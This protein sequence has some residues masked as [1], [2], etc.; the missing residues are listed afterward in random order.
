[1]GSAQSTKEPKEGKKT[2]AAENVKNKKNKKKKDLSTLGKVAIVAAASK[3][4]TDIYASIASAATG[5]E[6]KYNNIKAFTSSIINPVGFVKQAVEAATTQRL[7]VSRQNQQL[8]Y[9][10]QLTGNLVYSRKLINGTF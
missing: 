2:S 6:M 9:Q 1:M 5:E 4:T 7:I 10:Q 8:Q 3:I